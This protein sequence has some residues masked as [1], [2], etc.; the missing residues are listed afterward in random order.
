MNVW[1]IVSKMSISFLSSSLRSSAVRF[2]S[3]RRVIVPIRGRH[4]CCKALPVSRESAS[5][6]GFLVASVAVAG[7]A[8]ASEAK[9]AEETTTTIEVGPQ[10]AFFVM[11]CIRLME[12][13]DSYLEVVKVNNAEHILCDDAFF[14]YAISAYDVACDRVG[15]EEAKR[16]LKKK[17]EVFNVRCSNEDIM[18][19]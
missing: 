7:A 13:V 5:R 15:D 4:V 6:R 19:A 16:L 11:Q 12:I 18:W 1:F 2:D 3:C 9:G 10:D 17:Y 8:I 14:M